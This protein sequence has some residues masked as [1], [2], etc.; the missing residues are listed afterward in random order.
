LNRKIRTGIAFSLV[1]A[2][3]VMTAIALYADVPRMVA[4][5]THFRWALLPFI[6]GLT[7]LN[8]YWRFVKWQYYLWRLNIKLPWG[9]SLLIFL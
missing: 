3:V 7:L 2:F 5:L 6:L 8:Y 4:A 1:L 9:K